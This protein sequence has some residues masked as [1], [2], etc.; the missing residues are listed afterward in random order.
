[1]RSSPNLTK[2]WAFGPSKGRTVTPTPT[3]VITRALAA[4]YAITVSPKP[5]VFALRRSRL[6][7]RILAALG[8]TGNLVIWRKDGALMGGVEVVA[9][10][11]VAHSQCAPI[12]ALL[13]ATK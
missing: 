6:R 4:G 12:E 7:W 13:S 3:T 1:M 9:G 5:G 2:T 11:I 10:A 8:D